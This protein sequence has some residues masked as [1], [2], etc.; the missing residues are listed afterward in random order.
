[1]TAEKRLLSMKSITLLLAAAGLALTACTPA[2]IQPVPPATVYKARVI[3]WGVVI[4]RQD[5]S[6]V[7]KVRTALPF[8]EDWKFIKGGTQLVTKSRARHGAAIVEL[9]D[10]ATGTNQGSVKAYKVRNGQPS[11]AAEYAE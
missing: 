2:A 1:M 9:F 7:S 11:W 3:E 8:I 4:T 10:T 6:S 5:G